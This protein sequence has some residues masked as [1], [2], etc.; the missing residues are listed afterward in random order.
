LLACCCCC[1][2]SGIGTSSLS[3][4]NRYPVVRWNLT[5]SRSSPI[6]ACIIY[7]SAYTSIYNN[8]KYTTCTVTYAFSVLLGHAT[9]ILCASEDTYRTTE[10]LVKLSALFSQSP[11]QDGTEHSKTC[12]H[13][14]RPRRKARGRKSSPRL[15]SDPCRQCMAG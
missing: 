9:P 1:P 15:C 11:G 10:L 6:H 4:S 12:A 8:K 13:L 3:F 2:P 5:I 7:S 14:R